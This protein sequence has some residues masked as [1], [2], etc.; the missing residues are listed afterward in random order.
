M[1]Y[2]DDMFSTMWS[3]SV[4]ER[5]SLMGSGNGNVSNDG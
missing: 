2:T 5:Y 1:L 3:I 4:K